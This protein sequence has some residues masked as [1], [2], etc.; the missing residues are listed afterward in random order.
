MLRSLKRAKK[1]L[2][3]ALALEGMEAETRTEGQ[4]AMAQVMLLLGEVDSAQQLAEQTLEKARQFELTWLIAR[5]QQVLGSILE[6]RGQQRQANEQFEL[7][8]RTFRRHGMRLEYGHTL[9][10]FGEVLIQ[11]DTVG[12][13]QYQCGLNYLQEAQQIFKNCNAV[14]HEQI[15]K[16]ILA[17]YENVSRA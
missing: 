8:L 4:L 17:G 3:H 9:Q 1:T 10:I 14:A 6:T 16:Q 5:T 12:G 13:K 7:A 2:Q 11:R 15:V